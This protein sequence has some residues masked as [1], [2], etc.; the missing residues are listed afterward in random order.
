MAA[1]PHPCRH[2]LSFDTDEHRTSELKHPPDGNACVSEVHHRSPRRA[3]PLFP[4]HITPSTLPNCK[5]AASDRRLAETDSR[6]SA[7]RLAG[8]GRDTAADIDGRRA[9]LLQC[10]R[11]TRIMPCAAQAPVAGGNGPTMG[12]GKI[13]PA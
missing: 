7:G 5:P 3:R 6:L 12:R 10:Y 2:A 1:V 11:P 4:S 13:G 9:V 8:G